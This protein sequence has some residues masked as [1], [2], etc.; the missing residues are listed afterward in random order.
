[1]LRRGTVQDGAGIA[2]YEG[3]SRKSKAANFVAH[4]A[5]TAIIRRGAHV[6]GFSDFVAELKRR[7]V[8]RAL[9]GW[10]IVSF[11]ILQVIEPVLHAY[12]LPEWPLTLVVT[13]LGAGFPITAVLAWFFDI[14]SAGIIRTEPEA[15]P[16][17]G[18]RRL[19]GP[20]LA[21]ILVALGVLAA[22]PGLV[23]FFVWP[24]AARHPPL[25]SG[26]DPAS[27]VAPSIAVLPFA[28]MSP[29]KDQEYFADGISEAILNALGRVEGLH[30]IGRT[31][32]FSFKG[33]NDDLRTIGQKLNVG[34]ILQGS[35]R[36]EGDRVRIAAQIVNVANGYQ[37]WSKTFDHDVSGVFE[38]Q[39]EI[40][41][42]VVEALTVG[43]LPS[44]SPP[45]TRPA[46]SE[47]FNQYLIGRHA[48]NRASAEGFEIARV[49]FERAVALDTGYAAAWAA[50]ADTLEDLGDLSEAPAER[51]LF[52]DRA[53]AA[54]NR[55][56]ALGPQ[57]AD[58]YSVRGYVRS[59][60]LKW[61]DALSDVD[62]AVALNGSDAQSR[63][64][65]GQLLAAVGRVPEGTQELQRAVALD[66]LS[67]EAWWRLG[68]LYTAARKFELAR[69]ALNRSLE[70]APSQLY[71][72]RNLGF[73]ELLDGRLDAAERAF[74]RS[75]A[76]PFR[77]MGRALVEH[78][79]GHRDASQAAL[80]R[81]IAT[82]PIPAGYQIA[83]VFAWRGE[84]D[85]AMR[86]LELS[87]ER[88]DGGMWYVKFDPLLQRLRGD[89]RYAALLYKMNIPAD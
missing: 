74:E 21:V 18:G 3:A 56:V 49:A 54:T 9:F 75:T 37:L 17:V 50:L 66:P 25:A 11:A 32:S 16:G 33:K 10:G 47:A 77:L 38:V 48:L 41:R 85:E 84:T 5:H 52:D 22:A 79:R 27:V 55:A 64:V 7:G 72:G 69:A 51:R 43:L 6:A 80:D 59:R 76:E 57:L 86:W 58:G 19:A 67:A 45:P 87:L 44:R 89:P 14:T 82:S 12:H 13:G 65:R 73:V 35:V 39:D 1:L 40:G 88:T 61:T 28:D 36:K 15:S 62:R 53:L 23:Y 24:G 30:V 8:I 42:A 83:E 2:T 46:S 4:S 20:R 71:A 29:Q 60:S 26:P 81:L 78:E 34:T 31:S 70:I 63:I 68:W